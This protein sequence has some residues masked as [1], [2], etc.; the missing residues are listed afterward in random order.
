MQDPLPPLNALR[1]FMLVAKNGSLADA[2]NQLNITQ[3]AVSKRIRQLEA[4]LG[5]PL[6]IRGPNT[7]TLNATGLQ[8]ASQLQKVFEDIALAT[9]AVTRR[10]DTPLRIRCFTTWASRWLI[11]RLPKFRAEHP[12]CRI[13]IRTS[14]EPVDFSR[15][16][17]AAAVWSAGEAPPT[18]NA[19]RLQA[20][21]IAPFATPEFAASMQQNWETATLLG[22]KNRPGDWALWAAKTGSTLRGSSLVLEITSLAIDMALRGM[23]VAIA[24]QF[25]VVEE[26]SQGRLVQLGPLV[27]TG[28]RYWLALPSIPRS[29]VWI[30]RD[31]LTREV[32][33]DEQLEVGSA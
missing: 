32:E 1:S 10:E 6:F 27:D 11:P 5:A 26:L 33:A 8:Y 12:E 19:G 4:H 28:S 24:S 7:V 31:W 23:G 14:V 22:S 16:D 18:P 29:D 20:I 30:F 21:R 17:V 3:P 25:M 13:E 2:A 9:A 15:E